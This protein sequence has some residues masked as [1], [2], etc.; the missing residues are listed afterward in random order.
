MFSLPQN[1]EDSFNVEGVSDQQ[2]ITLFGETAEKFRS[3]M[4][5][6]YALSVLTITHGFIRA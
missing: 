3:L 2:P 4:W 1:P 5:I 6:L